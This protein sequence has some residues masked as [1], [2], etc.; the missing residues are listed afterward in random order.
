[1]RPQ[2]RGEDSWFLLHG[3]VPSHFAL[4]VNTFLAKHGVM[5]ISH[6]PHS[7]DLAP[8]DF[9]FVLKG[10]TFQDVEDIEKN[11][12][13]EL[14]AV[15]LEVFAYYFQNLFKRCNRYIQYGGDYFE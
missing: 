15:P 3:N 10:K 13:A 11:V 4:I 9:F 12:T 8:A 7:P 1:V 6:P 5:E 2:F 14:N